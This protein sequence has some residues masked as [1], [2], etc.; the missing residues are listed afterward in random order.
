MQP[1]AVSEANSVYQRRSLRVFRDHGRGMTTLTVEL[2]IE[3][4]EVISQA[5]DKAIEA[6]GCDGP[7]FA[8]TPWCAQQADA[9]VEICKGYLTGTGETRTSSAD[10][11]Q[12]V[13]HVDAE[14]LNGGKG[15]SDLPLESVRRISCD[16]T[17]V[18][19]TDGATGEPLSVGR[20]QRTV[21]TAI[22]RA[23]WARDH[24][25]SFP[26]CTHIRYVDAH[27]V[28]HWSKGGETSL[29]NLMLLCS[30]HHRL[31]HE[32][33][34]EICTDVEG[35]WYFKRSDGRAIPTL[36]YQ[37]E[38]MTDDYDAP[39]GASASAGAPGLSRRISRVHVGGAIET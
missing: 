33:G 7:E 18:T 21:P 19:M 2:P 30:Q 4:G 14:A 26:G 8:S 3:E 22:R 6:N 12:V 39:A 38:D 15:R 1:E 13:V 37:L 9:L 31:V 16:G 20:K 29:E 23:L 32:G 25:C 5:L 27:H 10:T 17:V 35:R 24:G 11:Y 36:G 28:R 34:Y